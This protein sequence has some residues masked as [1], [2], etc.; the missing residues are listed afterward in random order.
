MSK[1]DPRAETL[2]AIANFYPGGLWNEF[3][4]FA[5]TSLRCD[6][7]SWAQRLGGRFAVAHGWFRGTIDAA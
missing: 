7:R 4:R 6:G 3:S 5:L 2:G 1:A